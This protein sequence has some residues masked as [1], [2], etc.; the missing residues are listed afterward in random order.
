[1]SFVDSLSFFHV[2]HVEAR[3]SAYVVRYIENIYRGNQLHVSETLYSWQLRERIEL[4]L[5]YALSARS[6][7]FEVNLLYS[8]LATDRQMG[9][10]G[11]HQQRRKRGVSIRWEMFL[12]LF[13]NIAVMCSRSKYITRRYAGLWRGFESWLLNRRW[14]GWS[15]K[16]RTLYYDWLLYDMYIYISVKCI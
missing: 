6:V 4:P 13:G 2:T 5:V 16:L 10:A 14:Y 1:M 15:T 7:G 12:F 11:M 3:F 9:S 8:V